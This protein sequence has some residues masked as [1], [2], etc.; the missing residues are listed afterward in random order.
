MFFIAAEYYYYVYLGIVAILTI[1]LLNQNTQKITVD[2]LVERTIEQPKTPVWLIIAILFTLFIGLRPIHRVFVDMGTYASLWFW[3]IKHAKGWEDSN[4][5]FDNLAKWFNAYGLGY[6][7][8]FV[9]IAAIYFIGA[10]YAMKRI[11]GRNALLAYVV[12]LAAF[13]TFSYGTNG[14]KAGAAASLFLIAISFYG[15][16]WWA[17]LFLFLSL[18][19]HHSMLMPIAVFIL[20]WFVDKPKWYLGFW[21]IALAMAASGMT[22]IMEWM[23]NILQSTNDVQGS[24]YLL[25]NATGEYR[26]GFRPD[27]VLYSAIPV[28]LGYWI[29]FKRKLNSRFYNFV[30]SAYVIINGFWLLC[31]NAAFNNRIA[32]LSWAFNALVLVYPF[33]AKPF[34][35]R[36]IPMLRSVI[37]YNLLFTIFM[38]V[39]YY[40]FIHD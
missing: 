9:F 25:G 23:G 16:K 12:W 24:K 30:W 39:I 5:I 28:A 19:F 34:M 22:S 1:Y 14:I 21:L 3:S 38:Q 18:G 17:L 31:M 4:F 33:L 10:A 20:C 7:Y 32:Y 15:R 2:V 36:Q 29:I 26:T 8:F 37:V 40:Q 11:F 35:R 27:F 6:T 13:S